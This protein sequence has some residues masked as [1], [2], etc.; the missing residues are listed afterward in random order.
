MYILFEIVE[1][2]LQNRRQNYEASSGAVSAPTVSGVAK[3]SSLL[4]LLVAGGLLDDRLGITIDLALP[5]CW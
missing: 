1:A 3:H 4:N 2:I 5:Q